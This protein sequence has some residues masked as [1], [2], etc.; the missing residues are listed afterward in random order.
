MVSQY[1]SIN[2]CHQAMNLENSKNTHSVDGPKNTL[3]V[4]PVEE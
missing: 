1:I 3:I 2:T 4:S